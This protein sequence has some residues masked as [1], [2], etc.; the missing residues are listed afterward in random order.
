MLKRVTDSQRMRAKLSLDL[1]VAL[2]G[3]VAS[4]CGSVGTS[5]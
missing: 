4:G 2:D 1:A 3:P 5:A